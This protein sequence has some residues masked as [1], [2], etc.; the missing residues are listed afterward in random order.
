[1]PVCLCDVNDIS[2]HGVIF[3]L[4]LFPW[5][6]FRAAT[7]CPTPLHAPVARAPSTQ[8]PQAKPLRLA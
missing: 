4:A 6:K 2:C 8:P 1:M 3:F 7:C 5:V